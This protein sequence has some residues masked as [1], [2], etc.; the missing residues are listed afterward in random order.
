[1]RAW[2]PRHSRINTTRPRSL[3]PPTLTPI[4]PTRPALAA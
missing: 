1:M 3:T 4:R 2:C